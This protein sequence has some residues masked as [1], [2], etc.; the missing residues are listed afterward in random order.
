MATDT[1]EKPGRRWARRIG[2]L[3][4]LWIASVLSLFAAAGVLR[5]LMAWVGL[6]R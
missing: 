6:G 5:Y 4:L 2:W 1:T 3:V